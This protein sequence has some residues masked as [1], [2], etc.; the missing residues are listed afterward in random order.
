MQVTI[1]PASPSDA[2]PA[3]ALYSRSREAAALAKSIPPL[4][5]S[6]DDVRDWIGGFVIPKLEVWLAERAD[7]E[8]VGMLVL[9]DEWIDQ[10]YVDPGFTGMGIGT[11]LLDFAKRARPRGLRLWTFVSNAGAQ[12]FY[13][14]NGFREVERTDGSRNE[15]RAPDI[16]YKFLPT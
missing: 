15:E 10:L 1:R 12:R 2:Q 7:G 5:H 4:V 14:R 3:A 9:Q 16:Q 11:Q 6:D 8:I 13:E